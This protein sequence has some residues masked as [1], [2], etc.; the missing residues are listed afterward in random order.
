MSRRNRAEGDYGPL[1]GELVK[2]AFARDRVE[3]ELIQGLLKNSEIPSLLEQ[4]GLSVDGPQLGFGLATRGFGGGPQRVMVHAN[5]AEQAR[6]LLLETRV[7]NEEIT[8]EIANGEYLEDGDSGRAR[9]Y[10][11]IGGYARAGLWSLGV[12]GVAF[13]V[14]VLLRGVS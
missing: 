2:V 10:G 1:G 12:M 7:E 11:V 4:E 3:A 6:A 5:R 9:N 14:F 8:P 13:G